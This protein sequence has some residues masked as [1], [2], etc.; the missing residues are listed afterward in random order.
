MNKSTVVICSKSPAYAA[1]ILALTLVAMGRTLSGQQA[2]R[3]AASKAPRI[4]RAAP[5]DATTLATRQRFLEMFARAYFP[6]GPANS[7]WC[8]AKATSSRVPTRT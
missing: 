5:T 6:G 7:S 4:Q 3:S 2:K 1:I 8:R